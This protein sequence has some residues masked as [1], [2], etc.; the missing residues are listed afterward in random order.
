MLIGVQD[1][2]RNDEEAPRLLRRFRQQRMGVA[3]ALL[4][5]D[6]A[7]DAVLDAGAD[8]VVKG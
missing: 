4:E 5:L 1:D 8:T 6:P 2:D 3:L 7:D